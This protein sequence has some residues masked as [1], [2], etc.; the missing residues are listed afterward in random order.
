VQLFIPKLVLF[1]SYTLAGMLGR[2]QLQLESCGVCWVVTSTSSISSGLSYGQ[3]H[4][5][6]AQITR[7]SGLSDGQKHRSA[8]QITRIS[9]SL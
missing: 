5:S 2:H 9:G 4:R 1:F 7:I 3:K 6:A 8:A